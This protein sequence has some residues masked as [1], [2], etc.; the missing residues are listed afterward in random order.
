[1]N[2]K[3]SEPIKASMKKP[4]IVVEVNFLSVLFPQIIY[5]DSFYLY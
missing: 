3:V 5:G 4:V 2:D 1:M